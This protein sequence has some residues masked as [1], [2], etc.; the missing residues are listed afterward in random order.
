MSLIKL[1]AIKLDTISNKAMAVRKKYSNQ[2]GLSNLV[3]LILST[4]LSVP[5]VS[6]VMLIVSISNVNR[7]KIVR[8]IRQILMTFTFS[9]LPVFH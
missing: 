2:T 5:L 9:F 6:I 4:K 8:E 3:S 7:L 1:H